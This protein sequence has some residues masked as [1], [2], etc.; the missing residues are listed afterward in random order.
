MTSASAL[1]RLQAVMKR[2]EEAEARGEPVV[3]FVIGVRFADGR[4]EREI[5]WPGMYELKGWLYATAESVR[6]EPRR[7]Q[8]A[9]GGWNA[10]ALNGRPPRG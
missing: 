5:S 4:V 6:E 7:V 3:G 2:I 9:S 8:P 10:A 1:P